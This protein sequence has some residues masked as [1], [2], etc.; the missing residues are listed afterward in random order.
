[1]K[2]QIMY[3]LSKQVNLP[4]NLRKDV[5]FLSCNI[6]NNITRSLNILRINKMDVFVYYLIFLLLES[7]AEILDNK[8][9]LTAI[10]F[11]PGMFKFLAIFL[12]IKLFARKYISK[13]KKCFY[14]AETLSQLRREI[15]N[16]DLSENE[17]LERVA[18]LFRKRLNQ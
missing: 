11:I 9:K 15:G 1:M 12:L 17:Y 5:K 8:Q 7:K 16:L 13:H 14:G 6:T 18:F 4:Y 2:L 10:S 3:E